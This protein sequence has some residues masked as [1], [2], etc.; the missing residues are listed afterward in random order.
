SAPSTMARAQV[1]VAPWTTINL[2]ALSPKGSDLAVW[3]GDSRHL[4]FCSS[5]GSLYELSIDGTSPLLL[6]TS[7]S[8]QVWPVSDTRRAY[9]YVGAGLSYVVAGSGTAS[10]PIVLDADDANTGNI[11]VSR[12][13]ETVFYGAQSNAVYMV[14]LS[15]STP[16][17]PAQV[18]SD[19][20]ATAF[21]ISE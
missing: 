21:S 3:A 11:A 5:T 16:G 7:A 15:G 13:L 14:D 1:G 9:V 19:P 17:T 20:N 18:F 8:S 6:A 12:T 4:A 2:G 10:T